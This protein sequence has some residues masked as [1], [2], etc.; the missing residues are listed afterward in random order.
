MS[1]TLRIHNHIPPEYWQYKAGF[2]E[3]VYCTICKTL[4]LYQDMPPYKSC[5]ICGNRTRDRLKF[6][7]KWTETTK[8]VRW[9]NPLTWWRKRTG[10]WDLAVTSLADIPYDNDTLAAPLLWGGSWNKIF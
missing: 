1:K 3:V 6:I 9:W 7:A 4:A 8:K 2:N 5:I 10:Y